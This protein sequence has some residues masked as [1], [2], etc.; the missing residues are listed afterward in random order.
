MH[1]FQIYCTDYSTTGVSSPPP[2]APP[3]QQTKTTQQEGKGVGNGLENLS[4]NK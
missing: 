4:F 2:P 1:N 3:L